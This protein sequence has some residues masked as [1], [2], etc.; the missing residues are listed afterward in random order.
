VCNYSLADP[1]RGPAHIGISWLQQGIR[2]RPWI[3]QKYATKRLEIVFASDLHKR[4]SQENKCISCSMGPLQCHIPHF[5]GVCTSHNGGL[6]LLNEQTH[7]IGPGELRCCM[8][9]WAEKYS[10]MSLLVQCSSDCEHG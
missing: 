6:W 4:V 10:R 5:M 2:A 3:N 7:G 9:S 8:A 1:G